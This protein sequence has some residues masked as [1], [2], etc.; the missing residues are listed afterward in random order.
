MNQ[1]PTT[2]PAAGDWKI[3]PALP[4]EE[5]YPRASTHTWQEFA[6][7]AVELGG[8]KDLTMVNPTTGQRLWV[9]I[10]DNTWNRGFSAA[11][12]YLLDAAEALGFLE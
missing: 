8:Y 2:A 5:C 6:G 7:F 11:T 3:S 10:P 4:A 9:K 1:T 12:R